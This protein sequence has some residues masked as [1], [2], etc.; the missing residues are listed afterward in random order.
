[1]YTTKITG[2]CDYWSNYDVDI[3]VQWSKITRITDEEAKVVI[4]ENTKFSL[5]DEKF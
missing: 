5:E 1:M 4:A 3:D 2:V